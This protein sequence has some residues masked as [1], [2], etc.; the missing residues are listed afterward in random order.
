MPRAYDMATGRKP[1]KVPAVPDPVPLGNHNQQAAT[2]NSLPGNPSAG[3][4]K[5]LARD[6]TTGGGPGRPETRAGPASVGKERNVTAMRFKPTSR[7][8]GYSMTEMMAILAVVNVVL[9]IVVPLLVR[10]TSGATLRDFGLSFERWPQQAAVGIV[11]ALAAAPFVYSIQFIALR[12]W[13]NNAHPLQKMLRDEF[14]PGVAELAI[15]SGV[16]IAPI[17]EELL[18]RGVL[19]NWLVGLDRGRTLAALPLEQTSAEHADRPSTGMAPDSD[20]DF[21]DADSPDGLLCQRGARAKSAISRG[22]TRAVTRGIVLTSFLFALIHATQWPAPIALFLLALVIG[23]VYQR[24][25][26]LIAAIS[27]HAT[28]N[29]LS[30]L[31][32]LLLLLTG[33]NVDAN[34]VS[35]SQVNTA[36]IGSRVICGSGSMQ[37]S[38]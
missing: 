6:L 19:Q 11:A 14:S 26:S 15:L 22:P 30:T 4:A 8:T 34:K 38:P 25:G 35:V 21:W 28:F 27:L 1:V 32:M 3:S 12:I 36:S 10:L 37:P 18:F 24:T 17:F 20:S 9:V 31:V 33:A 7:E 2:K 13:E 16:I 29:G 23:T 5:A